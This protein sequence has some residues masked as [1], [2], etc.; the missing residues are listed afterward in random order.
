[1]DYDVVVIGSGAG[2]LTAA[3]LL[4]KG[5]RKVLVLE[6]A[7]G[8]GGYAHAYRRGEYTIDPAVHTIV[9]PAMFDALLRYLDVREECELLPVDVFFKIILPEASVALPLS[10]LDEVIDNFAGAFPESEDGIRSFFEFCAEFHRQAHE[11]PARLTLHEL[12]EAARQYPVFVKN[13]KRVLHDIVVEHVN[14]PKAQAACEIYSWQMG[15]P[16][17]QLSFQVFAQALLSS[18]KE[19]AFACRGG[20]QSMIDA[21]VAAIEQ[22]GGQLEFNIRV[23]RI[24]IDNGRVNGVELSNGQTVS[25]PR[26]LSNAD[27][28]ET[29]MELVGPD[30]LPPA[31]LKRFQ[32]L[33]PSLSSFL[34]YVG[35]SLD[36][37]QFDIRHQM[38][39][40]P[41][42]DIE[43]EMWAMLEGTTPACALWVPTLTDPSLAPPGEDLVILTQGA[44]YGTGTS[45]SEEADRRTEQFLD[46]LE[47]IFPGVRN[48]LVFVESATPVTLKRFTSNR[49]GAGY[50]WDNAPDQP[51]SKRPPQRPPV[52]GL[53]L[54]GAW[55]VPGM[56]Y[57]RVVVSGISA[58]N[59]I[60]CE[61]DPEAE[62]FE[63]PNLPALGQAATRR[64]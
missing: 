38:F 64:S 54:A 21:K 35:T 10:T 15:L 22:Y 63:H 56:G 24:L 40:S 28:T 7:P 55:T 33:R 6:Q 11:F 30:H 14:D 32:R 41:S 2:G 61:D 1:M 57:L 48:E 18:V 62:V 19:G 23:S 39:V 36:L 50:G 47:R 52:D 4:A 27:A 49:D 9:D 25:A 26:V 43:R 31:F 8:P 44:T 16:P 17:S 58:A 59:I 5:G 29:F 46:M 42:W 20:A 60:L 45:W 51:T 34:L 3:A 12:D 13:E 37:K 53:Y